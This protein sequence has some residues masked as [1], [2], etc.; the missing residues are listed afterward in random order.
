MVIVQF[1][2]FKVLQPGQW[3]T[4]LV[5]DFWMKW[6]LCNEDYCSCSVFAFSSYFYDL[7]VR[8]GL[9]QAYHWMTRKGVKVFK[10]SMM[11]IPINV[12]GSLLWSLCA[13]I[14]PSLVTVDHF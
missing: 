8:E 9:E 4:E 14:N 5:I 10:K 2:D 6:L 7:L 3:F 12:K 13:I 11:F 1:E